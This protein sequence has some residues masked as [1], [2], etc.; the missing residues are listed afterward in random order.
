MK[1]KDKQSSSSNSIWSKIRTNRVLSGRHKPRSI[2][3][4]KQNFTKTK[5]TEN[6][7]VSLADL[8]KISSLIMGGLTFA[9]LLSDWS[10]LQGFYGE[11]N[12]PDLTYRQFIASPVHFTFR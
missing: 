11:L 10:F 8:G 3:K 2:R 4:S 6:K 9:V 5:Q 1:R 12:V 7:T